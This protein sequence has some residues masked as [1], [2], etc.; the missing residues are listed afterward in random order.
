MDAV[1]SQKRPEKRHATPPGA[2]INNLIFG[3]WTERHTDV[4]STTQ[5]TVE[6]HAATTGTD[7][8]G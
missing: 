5:T 2:V 7:A 4:A 3:T 8:T 1:I 6:A